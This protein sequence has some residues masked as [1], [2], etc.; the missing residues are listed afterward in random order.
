MVNTNTK[1]VILLIVLI[2][3][4]LIGNIYMIKTTVSKKVEQTDKELLKW[5]ELENSI[6]EM[7]AKRIGSHDGSIILCDYERGECWIIDK[8]GNI[9]ETP[10]IRHNSN[11]CILD[12]EQVK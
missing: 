6:L 9:K 5:I 12:G 7:G 1:I 11:M 4:A 10:R 8:H 3:C 2:S